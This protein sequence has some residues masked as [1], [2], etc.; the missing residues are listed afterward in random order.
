M[1]KNVECKRKKI[2]GFGDGL[3][4]PESSWRGFGQRGRDGLAVSKGRAFL[5]EKRDTNV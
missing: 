5:K 1:D 3:G 2:V 4:K